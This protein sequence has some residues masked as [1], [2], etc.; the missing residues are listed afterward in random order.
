M[1]KGEFMKQVQRLILSYGESQ[2]PVERIN[3]LWAKLESAENFAFTRAVNDVIFRMPPSRD[4]AQLLCETVS[5]PGAAKQL[6]VDRMEAEHPVQPNAAELA[7]KYA[8]GIKTALKGFG[9]LP[10]D[11]KERISE[12]VD[13]QIARA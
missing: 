3:L 6:G 1:T 4:V 13:D 8:P 12:E 5:I 7:A 10:Y 9:D 2:W 11:P